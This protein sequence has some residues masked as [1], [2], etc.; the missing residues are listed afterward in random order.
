M[1]GPSVARINGVD[2]DAAGAAA[3]KSK[4]KGK[5]KATPAPAPATA[6]S[7]SVV[8]AGK[9]PAK[10]GFGTVAREKRFVNPSESGH[11]VPELEELVAPHIQSFD[12]LF[13]DGSGSG[14]G[15]L[16]DLAVRDLKSK[17]VFD[18]KGK[19][20]GKLGNR[21]ESG[22]HA[23]VLICC[24]LLLILS[25]RL[26]VKLD[27]VTVSRPVYSQKE[28]LPN[29]CKRRAAHLRGTHARQGALER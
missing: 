6:S 29:P 1:P 18:G 25:S 23:F 11:D 7:L 4:G 3:V 20:K 14:K 21:L 16:L 10:Y 12:A 9:K 17:V 24:M 8:A 27:T 26:T 2:G 28:D 22:L 13:D 5:G 15:G 19:D